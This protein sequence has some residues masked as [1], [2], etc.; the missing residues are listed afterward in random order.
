[1]AHPFN[2]M[3][4]LWMS[5]TWN[6]TQTTGRCR[7]EAVICPPAVGA[8][9]RHIDIPVQYHAPGDRQPEGEIGWRLKT[10]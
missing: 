9:T 3:F 6:S 5:Q 7:R 1:M 4:A 8:R 10:N 2:L